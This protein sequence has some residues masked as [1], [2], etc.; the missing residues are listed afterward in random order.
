[1]VVLNLGLKP[2]FA[3]MSGYSKYFQ[4]ED[5]SDLHT[6]DQVEHPL[7]PL[8]LLARQRPPV[9]AYLLAL[10]H[11]EAALKKSIRRLFSTC[12]VN[13]QEN[14]MFKKTNKPQWPQSLIN[15]QR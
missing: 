1:V 2:D 9:I 10:P 13:T 15:T 5:C 8:P 12:A 14:G 3:E 7:L 6:Q 11:S 4:E